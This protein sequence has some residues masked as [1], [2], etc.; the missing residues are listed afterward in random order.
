MNRIKAGDVLEFIE[1][2]HADGK[3]IARGTKVRVG[4]VEEEV[5]EPN[6]TVVLLDTTPPQTLTLPRHILTVHCRHLAG[7]G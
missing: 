4:Y 7:A 5:L 2:A 3:T 1:P 6:V